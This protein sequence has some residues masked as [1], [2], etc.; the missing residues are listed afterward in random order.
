MSRYKPDD[1]A[2]LGE[3]AQKQ[4]RLAMLAATMQALEQKRRNKFGA[5]AYTGADGKHHASKG[6]GG[7]WEELKLMQR[8]GLI[9]GLIHQPTFALEVNGIAICKYRAD[10]EYFTADGV[11]VVED[12]KSPATA[13]HPVYRI[14]RALMAAIHGI[15]I[16][17]VMR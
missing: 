7:R 3:G 15:T 12:F 6:E 10:A 16:T 5:E 9:E 4:I 14:K 8:A 17:E 1:I 11:R 13:K 2:R